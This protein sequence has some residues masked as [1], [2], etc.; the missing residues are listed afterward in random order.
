MGGTLLLEVHGGD[1]QRSS[2]SHLV[3]DGSRKHRTS[4][5][6]Q[7]WSLSWGFFLAQAFCYLLHALWGPYCWDSTADAKSLSQALSLLQQELLHST[8]MACKDDCWEGDYEEGKQ[9]AK[10]LPQQ[11][12]YDCNKAQIMPSET[13]ELHELLF[14]TVGTFLKAVLYRRDFAKKR[15]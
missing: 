14:Q 9:G 7:P 8:K 13:D 2:A 11:F 1:E 4:L 12:A 15:K 5:V 10:W 3:L 6:L